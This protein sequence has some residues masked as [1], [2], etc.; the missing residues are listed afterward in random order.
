[1]KNKR[2]ILRKKVSKSKTLHEKAISLHSLYCN[3]TGFLHVLPNFYIIGTAKGGTSSL[4]DYLIQHPDVIS[5]IGKELHFFEEL[6]KRGSNWYKVCFPTKI[7]RLFKKNFITGE[8]TPRYID[9]PQ[10]PK[11]INNLT[12]NAKFIVM[13]RNPIDR[14]FSHYS[15][16]INGKSSSL[17]PLPFE[18]AIL[19][20][21]ERIKGEFEKME[22]ESTYSSD[23]YWAYAYQ[24]RGLYAKKLKR[25]MKI[26]SP[27]KFFIIQSEEFFR[28]PDVIYNQTL[29]FLGLR[30]YN[31][32]NYE[33]VKV[34]KYKSQLKSETREFLSAYFKPYNEELFQLIGR[35]FDWD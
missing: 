2:I 31:L 30:H 5:P 35:R 19:K 7:Q 21:S 11:R 34:G 9:H 8:A 23:K 15:M 10:V 32:S 1:M 16:I 20:E 33:P 12:P 6:Y 22:S 13:L 24:D 17:E 29:K 18:D 27:E 25:W 4:F 3:I 28:N 26:F 14:A